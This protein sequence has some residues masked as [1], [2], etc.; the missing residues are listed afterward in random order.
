[1]KNVVSQSNPSFE[2]LKKS[3]ET[4]LF[5][6][7][8]QDIIEVTYAYT[9]KNG[10]DFNR[11]L[12]QKLVKGDPSSS[13]EDNITYLESTLLKA[14]NTLEWKK[15]L[16]WAY[17][18]ELESL[19]SH[20]R[21]QILMG[22]IDY[23]LDIVDLTILWLPFEGEKAGYPHHLSPDEVETRVHQMEE[24]ESRL[25]WGNIRNDPQEVQRA[26]VWLRQ[27]YEEEK[28]NLTPEEQEEFTS[29]I[30]QVRSSFS[31]EIFDEKQ[32]PE[33]QIEQN[34]FLE[35]EISREAYVK[36]FETMFAMY[37][38]EKPVLVDER[39]SIYD[40]A[41]ALCIPQSDQ[42]ATLPL[43]RVLNLIAHEIETHYVIE[44]NNAQT[45]WDFRGWGNLQR[46]E[47][48]A[49]TSERILQGGN[50][51][52][53]GSW[54]SI[55]SLLF[56][57]IL[58]GDTYARFTELRGKLIGSKN[59]HG[60]YLRAKRN[61][62]LHYRGVQHKDTSYNRGEHKVAAF[63]KN[64]WEVKDLYVGKVNFDDITQAKSIIASENPKLTYP[65]LIGEIL[66]YVLEGHPLKENEFFD[67]IEKKYP[68]LDIRSEIANG[69]IERLNVATKRKVI[70]ILQ[71]IKK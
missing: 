21:I 52:D 42:Y 37:G 53:I 23:F 25:F 11:T 34:M 20:P 32:V 4:D 8:L 39:S 70:Q 41:D 24:I 29:Y 1:M 60:M 59:S 28:N 63:L 67:F 22:S 62:P 54:P 13:F 12:F 71:M 48:L 38:I 27:L 58:D 5:W 61:Y 36:I 47:W 43:N 31:Y 30:E 40:W 14:Q 50:L 26:F 16:A 64:G 66:K 10:L 9:S 49:K 6:E 57:E 44:K 15:I 18:K 33:A 46:E 69:S 51:D 65:L 3:I 7:E 17:K 68:F 2:E 55:P 45:L 56:G 19:P 35:K